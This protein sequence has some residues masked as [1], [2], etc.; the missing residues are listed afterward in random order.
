MT[1]NMEENKITKH[2]VR[3]GS[4]PFEE[5]EREREGSFGRY[6]QEATNDNWK[7][8]HSNKRDGPF[9]RYVWKAT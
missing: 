8:Y 6:V 9:K 1:Q 5:R 3:Y 4:I 7:P 2:L